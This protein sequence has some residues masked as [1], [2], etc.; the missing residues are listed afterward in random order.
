ML[1]KMDYFVKATTFRRRNFFTEKYMCQCL[2]FHKVVGLRPTTLL[3]QRLWHRCFPV[4]FAK[5]LRTP[6]FTE[7]LRW[8]LLYLVK[9]TTLLNFSHILGTMK[10]QQFKVIPKYNYN[11]KFL[12]L[13]IFDTYLISIR[14]F[15]SEKFYNIL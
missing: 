8:L 4:D 15:L 12:T 10:L 5:F 1:G 13:K 2:F 7:H 14:D 11:T 6:I 3:K 9:V